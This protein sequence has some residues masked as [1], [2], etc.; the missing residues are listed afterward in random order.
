M[1][2]LI[3]TVTVNPS[4]DHTL[5][6]DKVALY[7]TNRAS[8]VERDAGGKGVNVSRVVHGLGGETMA[9]G[10]LG[11]GTGAYVRAILASEG[12]RQNF[13]EIADETRLNFA[14]EASDG[15]PPT[16][17]SEPGP[18]VSAEELQTLVANLKA[19]LF[20]ASWLVVGGSRPCGLP[21]DI[22]RRLGQIARA[23][24]VP[25]ALDADGE[26]LL[27]GLLAGPAFLKPNVA[28]ASRLLERPLVSLS[29]I[30]VA[31]A[32]IST[33]AAYG[34]EEP[35]VVISRG[36]EGAVMRSKGEFWVGTAP[37]VVCNSTVGSGDS[38]VGAMLTSLARGATPQDALL[39]G[40]AAGA[41]TAAKE[42]SGL[43]TLSEVNALLPFASVVPW[44][45]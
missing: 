41:A 38:M 6:V 20:N 34:G 33:L 45:P 11:G 32:E 21:Q 10:F 42:G 40:L 44:S 13:I 4:V 8:R 30:A 24:G 35:I 15:N 3:L 25:F 18:C 31:A 1:S 43:A 22:F 39:H 26:L 19:C 37:E 36:R 16:T 7:D 9:S 23:E 28:E 5:F 27:A 29:D 2:S 14:V 12:V 17:F